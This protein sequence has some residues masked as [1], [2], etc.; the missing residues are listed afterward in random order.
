MFFNTR[1]KHKKHKNVKQ[2]NKKNKNDSYAH[3]TLNKQ[4]NKQNDSYAHETL[5]KRTKLKMTAMR[6][7][8][9]K[10]RKLPV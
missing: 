1:K 10:G 7:N 5:N 6:I 4:T 3:K 2:G 8:R 9:L